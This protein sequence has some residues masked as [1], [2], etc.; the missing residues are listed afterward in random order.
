MKILQ[1]DRLEEQQKNAQGAM[2][3]F[4]PTSRIHD[5]EVF[6]ISILVK[7][8]LE[9]D[10]PKLKF[11]YRRE[12]FKTEINESLK[13][14]DSCLGGTIYVENAKI[15]PDG[16][17]LE[18]LDDNGKWR[19][20]LVSEAKYQGKDIK[21]IKKGK[22]VGKF[23]DQDCMVAGN[24]IERAYKNLNEIANYMLSE[25]YFPYIIFLEG[26]NFLT[27]D[28]SVKRPDG[29]EVVLHYNDGMI[30]RLDR[31]TSA[32][33]GM[34]FN[35]NLCENK[36]VKVN[37]F[38]IMLQSASIYTKGNGDNWTENEIIEIML[39]VAKTALKLLAKDLFLQ[40]TAK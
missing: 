6:N 1:S 10:Y 13:K 2:S 16:G 11:R 28:V 38:S 3:I 27:Q 35:T 5:K 26:S 8:K 15:K 25:I 32:N 19:V 37:G 40:I 21:N 4:H 29:R 12:L 34:P 22:L 9:N 17:I 20:V 18:V 36:F 31:L 14:I 33:Y 23:N 39:D 30:N 24:A 7:N